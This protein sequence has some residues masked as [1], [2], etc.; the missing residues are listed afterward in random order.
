MQSK[1]KPK[2]SFCT[3]CMG[4][5]PHLK[6]TLTQNIKDNAD[7]P[8]VQFVVVNYGAEAETEN[9][10][11]DT[12]QAEIKSGLLKY[13]SFPGPKH[14]QVS[15][16]KNVA[17]M[18]GDG[19]I[20]CNVDADQFIGKD[21]ARFAIE[22]FDEARKDGQ[23]IYLRLSTQGTHDPEKAQGAGRIAVLKKDFIRMRGYDEHRRGWTAEDSNLVMRMMLKSMRH[24]VIPRDMIHGIVHDDDMRVA[25]FDDEAKASSRKKL[26]MYV[27]QDDAVAGMSRWGAFAYKAFTRSGEIID[28]L[29]NTVVN[30]RGFAVADV[31]VNFSETPEKSGIGKGSMANDILSRDDDAK[32]N[33]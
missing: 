25:N 16:A 3:T 27:K 1:P 12:F 4:R 18:M 7:N 8:D 11:R 6:E 13:I 23:H 22:K 19:E 10:I 15:H 20:V 5:L 17:H 30:K 28:T 14:F 21:F 9:W 33:R 29:M 31:Y 2:I 32:R 24:E 26:A